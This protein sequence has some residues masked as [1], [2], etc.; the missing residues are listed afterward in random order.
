MQLSPKLIKHPPPTYTHKLSSNLLIKTD[1]KK[2]K[3]MNKKN[4]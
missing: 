2:L 3:K 4:D 1:L